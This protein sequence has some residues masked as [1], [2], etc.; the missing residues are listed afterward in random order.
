M[1]KNSV[2]TSRKAQH[3]YVVWQKSNETGFLLNK[4]FIIFTNQGYPLQNSSLGQLHSDGGVVSI[5][6]SSAERLLLVYFSARRLRSSG[7]YPNYQNGALSSGFWAGAIKRSYR[8]RDPANR[9]LRNHRNA[10]FC[11]IFIDGDCRVTWGVVMQ[12]PSACNAWSHTCHPFPMSFKDFPIKRLIDSLS[13]WHKFLVDDPW[14]SKNKRASIWFWI[15]SF[16]LSWDGESLQCATLG[17]GVLSRGSTPK[18]MIH[19][20]W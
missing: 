14:L 5:V 15:Y 3:M 17:F 20:L 2:P 8:D 19:H 12:H 4:H 7:Y 9:G 16:S 10:F 18:S 6:R 1:F 11:Q 13:C